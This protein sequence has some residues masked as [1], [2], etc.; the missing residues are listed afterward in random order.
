M[1]S[2]SCAAADELG[3]VV[4][5]GNKLVFLDSGFEQVLAVSDTHTEMIRGVALASN[6]D[7]AAS[8]GDDKKVVIWDR[9]KGVLLFER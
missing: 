6:G 1:D 8:V 4:T 5:F 9:K 2:G 3:C 7:F